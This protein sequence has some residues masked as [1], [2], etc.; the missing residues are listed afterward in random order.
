MLNRKN[1][2]TNVFLSDAL[3]PQTISIVKTR[4]QSLGLKITVGNIFDEN[5]NDKKYCGILFQYPD[6]NGDIN[7]YSDVVDRAHK[8]GV[9]IY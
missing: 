8:S 3:H 9:R 2:K 4:A 1:N 6:T 7:D 5:F